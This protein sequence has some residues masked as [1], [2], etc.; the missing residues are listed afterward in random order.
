MTRS[1]TTI[2]LCVAGAS[3]FVSAVTAPA[4]TVQMRR[5]EYR[6]V[7][8]ALAFAEEAETITNPLMWPQL[9]TVI[10]DGVYVEK[11]A[12]ITEFDRAALLLR[13]ENLE[14]ERAIV[15]A[16]LALV[17]TK[18]RNRDMDLRDELEE[19]RD[20][21]AVF[22]TQL[23]RY[24]SLP[25]PDDV[26]I[27]KGRLHVATLEYEAAR[28]DRERA[29]SRL[30]RGMI[31]PGEMDRYEETYRRKEALKTYRQ[32]ML[33][34][35][36]LPATSATIRGTELAIANIKLEIE[37]LRSEAERNEQISAIEREGAN[38]RVEIIANQI[39][40]T[41]TDLDNSVVRAP[42]AGHVVYLPMFRKYRG[43]T[44]EK[45]WKDFAYMRMP[46][47]DTVA[48]KGVVLETERRFFEV[49][50]RV[51]V[52]VSGRPEEPLEGTI[53][54]FS[55]LSHDRAEKEVEHWVRSN[56]DS[57]IMVYDVVV[58]A[59]ERPDWLRVGLSAE[60]E[61][62]ATAPVLAPSV[63]ITLVKTR[64]GQHHLSFDGIYQKVDGT[65][66]DGYLALVDTGLVGRAVDSFGLFPDEASEEYLNGSDRFRASGELLP[67]D[68]E[69]V[70][71]GD[72]YRWQKVSW[73]I[74]E[75][76]MVR[77][78]D[79]VARLDTVE[80]DEA[81]K[82][83]ETV[84]RQ[85]VSRREKEEEDLKMRTEENLFALARASNLCAIARLEVE[86][87][88][89][90][91][92]TADELKARYSLALAE[93]RLE[94]L[95]RRLK[96]VEKSRTT[97][98]SPI[99]IA[100][101]KRDCRRATLELEAARIGLRR[102]LDLP[103]EVTLSRARLEH[104]QC[105]LSVGNLEKKLETD[106][107]RKS[108]DLTRAQREERRRRDDLD[109][110]NL[111]KRNLTLKAPATG[112]VRYG[113]VRNSGVW[114]KVSVGSL[115]TDHAVIVRIADMTRMYV[116]LEV[117]ERYFTRIHENMT[118][119]LRMRSQSGPP[120]QGR[121]SEIEFLFQ[122]KRRKDADRG[123]YSSHES[124]GETVFFVRAEVEA[125]DGMPLKP[126]AVAEVV[127]PFKTDG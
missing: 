50:D 24:R 39:E 94:F 8:R 48:L 116:R 117:P 107:S 62:I 85:A 7:I 45:M 110:R 44:A 115:V 99:E 91:R 81:I 93:V 29:G 56:V 118:V 84:M 23:A 37:K 32:G 52:R 106:R 6:T 88:L 126:G 113:K 5:F 121:I 28:K 67:A 78:G 10:P 22:E 40:D 75:D 57:G 65:L 17:L 30:E 122:R 79:V 104:L 125:Q 51:I 72:I 98:F 61:L 33:E 59:T 38:A 97:A 76:T 101:L 35:V 26:A 55:T 3:L 19:L 100:N 123:L 58:E 109:E 54:S 16:S 14:R 15:R 92:P 95:Q 68:T 36:S 105:R 90:E 87:L 2:S 60:C 127:F 89:D 73:L 46:H 34:L 63:P 11:G 70:V 53:Q 111:E 96:R 20:R 83:A 64:N 77:K 12:V 43:Y 42:I 9:K 103:E 25:E 124:L 66:I 108:Y 41:Q 119:D 86:E 112:L 69:E 21:L 71:I 74:S 4:E 18:I 80:T 13:L 31:S 47:T 82:K 114:S 120:I 27:A 49:G 102:L 1:R